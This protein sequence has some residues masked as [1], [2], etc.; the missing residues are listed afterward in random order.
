MDQNTQNNKKKLKLITSQDEPAFLSKLHT[1]HGKFP[2]YTWKPL[3]TLCIS[4]NN[5]EMTFRST[6]LF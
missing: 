6:F 5:F 1:V 3:L 2:T 4:H